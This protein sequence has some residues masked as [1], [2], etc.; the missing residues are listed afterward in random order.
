MPDGGLT[1]LAVGGQ[2]L[3]G[4]MG[5]KGNQAAARAAEQVAEYNAQVAE[6]EA[7]LLQRQKREEE[8]A[9][10]RQ[11]DRLIST[12]RVAT[13][14]SG[15]R[16]SG[17][18]LQALADAYF[19][20]EKDAARIQY[21]SS[22]QQMQKESEATLSRLEG[23]AQAQAFRTQAQQSLLGGFTDAASTGATLIA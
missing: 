11:S 12:Q 7:I 13:A 23:R 9:L 22:I 19:N 17:S 1:A 16:M 6:N 21:A 10:R 15:I 2:V 20:T 4:I 8:S 5:S 3:G 18:P 14:T